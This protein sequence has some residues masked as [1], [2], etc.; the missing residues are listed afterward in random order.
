MGHK[1]IDGGMDG[2]DRGSSFN[3]GG[4]GRPGGGAVDMGGS[5][6]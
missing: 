5:A 4:G 1:G 6:R 2:D 3:S